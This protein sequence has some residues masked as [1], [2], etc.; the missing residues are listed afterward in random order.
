MHDWMFFHRSTRKPYPGDGIV[1]LLYAV[2]GLLQTGSLKWGFTNQQCVP[3]WG[4]T[5]T[6]WIFICF[7][8]GFMFSLTICIQVT[9]YPLH[10]CGLFCKAPPVQYSWV[11]HTGSSS[12]HH[13]TQFWWPN[14]SPLE[15]H[16]HQSSWATVWTHCFKKKKKTIPKLTPYCLSWGDL[17]YFDLHV[18]VEEDVPQLQ[19]SVNDFVLVQI[20]DSLQ[21][22]CHEV[23]SLRLSHS[24]ATL[25]QLQQRLKINIVPNKSAIIELKGKAWSKFKRKE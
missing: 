11:F 1:V 13:Q 23:A 14:Q 3:G 16:T 22:L 9:K 6:I 8:F 5:M 7:D 21:K 4:Q 20:M 19:V 24:F 2:V 10:S 12:S 17:T 15:K 18:V 25:V